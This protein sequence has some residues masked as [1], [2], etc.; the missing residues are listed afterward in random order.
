MILE[1]NFGSKFAASDLTTSASYDG[2]EPTPSV[3]EVT[4]MTARI[5]K[6]EFTYSFPVGAGWKYVRLHFYSTSYGDLSSSNAIFSVSSG[7]YTLLKDFSVSETSKDLNYAITVEEFLISVD[8]GRLNV[9]FTPSSNYTDSY[10]LVN[11][12]SSA[13]IAGDK[14]VSLI[15]NNA[16][17]LEK[18]VPLN[19]GGNKI[20]PVADTGL[21]RSWSDHLMI[22]I[23]AGNSGYEIA[24]VPCEIQSVI[25][26]V[27]QRVFQIFLNNQNVEDQ[28]DVVAWTG[29]TGTGIPLYK[30][31]AVPEY[32]DAIYNGLEI[33]K[34]NDT[35]GNLAAERNPTLA[36]SKSRNHAAKVLA[37]VLGEVTPICPLFVFVFVV[38]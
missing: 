15:I 25:T 17:V 32:Y 8:K 12:I 34:V 26:K 38:F 20:S 6:S 36:P 28:A 33:F 4:Y 23:F 7:A 3:A 21:F 14:G 31:N 11:G 24:F 5:F 10:A 22:H 29:N 30:N 1:S 2:S 37:G 35:T 9:I 19:V 18:V 16:T 27:N 13:I